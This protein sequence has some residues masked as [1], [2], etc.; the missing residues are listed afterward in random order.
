VADDNIDAIARAFMPPHPARLQEDKIYR[1]T[2]RSVIALSN[3]ES[4]LRF[5]F[6]VLLAPS[7]YGVAVSVFDEVSNVATKLKLVD[8]LVEK[9]C[10]DD[11]KK[12]WR[13]LSST[14][15]NHKGI[16]NLV[17]H[18]RMGYEDV[19]GPDIQRV[20]LEPSR[21][22]SKGK[23]LDGNDIARTADA[24]VPLADKVFEFGRDLAIRLSPELK[25]KWK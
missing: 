15:S 5:L 14:I 17:A 12:A 13:T 18:Q 8:V 24:L 10:N 19:G 16:R 21:A 3:I 23:R 22:G 25:E 7:P 11:E 9:V 1:E 2:G 20:I 6:G 4:D